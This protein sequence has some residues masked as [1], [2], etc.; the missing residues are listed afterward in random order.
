ML[1]LVLMINSPH[2][3]AMTKGLYFTTVVSS[4]FVLLLYLRRLISE[5]TERISTKL[6]HIFT[7]DWYCKNLVQTPPGIYPHGLGGKKRFFGTDL[8]LWPN[9]SLQ[10]NMISTI[11]KISQSTGTHLH[12]PKFGEFWS[13]NGWERLASFCP[14]PQ[15]SSC[16]TLPASPHGRYITDS[17]QTLACV[18]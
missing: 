14:P 1:L 12:A 3:I 5:I 7:Y 6:G 2:G 4:F 18:M 13:R 8:E 10:Q 11:R 16:E 9:I 15:F 17:R